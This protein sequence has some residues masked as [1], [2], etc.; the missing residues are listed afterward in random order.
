MRVGEHPVT[1]RAAVSDRL[2]VPVILGPE[3]PA[4]DKLLGVNRRGGSTKCSKRGVA[5]TQSQR[6]KQGVSQHNK[7]ACE[8]GSGS[9]RDEPWS[10]TEPIFAE[11]L[12]EGQQKQIGRDTVVSQ[13]KGGGV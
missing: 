9:I 2:P 3:V 7:V 12:S 5:V 6:R 10:L 13:E 4:F 11:A 8:R 1:V